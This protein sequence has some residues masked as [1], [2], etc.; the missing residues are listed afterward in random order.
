MTLTVTK[1]E[2]AFVFRTDHGPKHIRLYRDSRRKLEDA[3]DNLSKIELSYEEMGQALCILAA[4]DQRHAC[5]ILGV[6]YREAA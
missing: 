3:F 1:D 2:G 4:S 6:S 5:E